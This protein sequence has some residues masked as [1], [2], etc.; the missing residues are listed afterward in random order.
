[1]TDRRRVRRYVVRSAVELA[2][3]LFIV[4]FPCSAVS[5]VLVTQGPPS[6]WSQVAVA[7]VL[8]GGGGGGAVLLHLPI[9]ARPLA[10]GLTVEPR[11]AVTAA[12]PLRTAP[13]AAGTLPVGATAPVTAAPP[14][15]ARVLSEAPAALAAQR[16]STV[17]DALPID[18]LEPVVSRS[19]DRTIIVAAKP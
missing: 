1:M 11:D 5:L 6:P 18:P 3:S 16:L 9:E 8:G 14:T 12:A 4:L 10:A 19:G 17:G 13:I 2:S 15:S 7:P